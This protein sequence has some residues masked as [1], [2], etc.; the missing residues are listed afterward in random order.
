MHEQIETA[1]FSM[2]RRFHQTQHPS[3]KTALMKE[4][5]R[6]IPF[7][8]A[9]ARHSLSGRIPRATARGFLFYS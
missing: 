9:K 7:P 2:L 1:Q 8:L 6:R 5:N 4:E 3:S